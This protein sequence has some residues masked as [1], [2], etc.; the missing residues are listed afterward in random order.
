MKELLHYI[1]KF[2]LSA[3]F[4]SPTDNP[5]IGLFRY[6]FVG[7]ASFLVDFVCYCLLVLVGAHYLTAGILAF[8]ISFAVNFFVSRRI[9]F[10]QSKCKNGAAAE[11]VKVLAVALIGLVLTE[12]LL[13]AGVN[14][15]KLGRLLS[16]IVA[17][18]IVLVWN[19][20]GRRFFVY[21]KAAG[22]YMTFFKTVLKM[23]VA[24]MLC[25]VIG[26]AALVAVY[27]IPTDGINANIADSVELLEREGLYP[28]L[29]SNASS[30][31]DSWT[32]AIMLHTAGYETTESPV[33]EAVLVNRL[34][35]VDASSPLDSLLAD[36]KNT[37]R[38]MKTVSYSRYWHGY[39][40]VLKPLLTQ[41]TYEEIRDINELVQWALVMLLI[42]LLIEKKLSLYIVPVVFLVGLQGMPA[43]NMSL[44]FSNVFYVYIVGMIVLLG[45]HR[46]WKGTDKMTVF[47]TLLGAATAFVDLLTY[48]LVSFG[49]P[50]VLLLALEKG[51]SLLKQLKTIVCSGFAWLF[52]FAGMWFGKGA[53]GTLLTGENIFAN[54]RSAVDNKVMTMPEDAEPI[55][56][57]DVMELN[58]NTFISSDYFQAS[59]LFCL[60]MLSL[61]LVRAFRTK[62]FKP[63][64]KELGFLL[65]CV[66]PVC[67]YV[68]LKRHSQ[69]HFWFT[70]RNYLIPLFA[71][72]VMLVNMYL[73]LRQTTDAGRL[74][75]GR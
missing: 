74:S 46:R 20:L 59:Q 6:V 29:N 2:D 66:A 60:L 26:M 47:F 7:G 31:L 14:L 48:P 62:Q 22:G 71:M 28:R 67:W 12:V 49:V 33:R 65:I 75:D 11:I 35:C 30:Q 41:Y 9:V 15:L 55:L 72:G 3:L 8:V 19:Y 54:M 51:E 64:W 13:F 36:F 52:G 38:Q 43:T 1:I 42:A 68:L 21:R 40:V 57:L 63:L 10:D 37:D 58:W 25:A 27:C 53:V 16:K 32:D 56:P 24:V 39:L 73:A 17:S 45:C 69:V 61:V 4:K 18:A 70:F 44:Q 5:W 34:E 50:L 23:V